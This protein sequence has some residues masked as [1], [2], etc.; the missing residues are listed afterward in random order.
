MEVKCRGKGWVLATSHRATQESWMGT[1]HRSSVWVLRSEASFGVWVFVAR[2]AAG[3]PKSGWVPVGPLLSVCHHRRI[4]HTHSPRCLRR[5]S[6]TERS[7]GAP[8]KF[9]Q[10]LFSGSPRVPTGEENGMQLCWRGPEP[11]CQAP[12][13]GGVGFKKGNGVDGF[14]GALWPLR[15]GYKSGLSVGWLWYTNRGAGRGWTLGRDPMEK[16]ETGNFLEP[17]LCFTSDWWLCPRVSQLHNLWPFSPHWREMIILNVTQVCV[18]K[19]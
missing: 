1:R 6:W 14:G 3:S 5:H 15:R 13:P 2:L 16:W 8:V 7:R 19:S 12:N 9:Q 4:T 10:A 18:M 17:N 11:G